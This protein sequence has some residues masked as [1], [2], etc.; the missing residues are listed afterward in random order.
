MSV[1]SCIV[2]NVPLLCSDVHS[3]GGCACVGVGSIG[4]LSI[5]SAQFFKPKTALKI[6]SIKNCLQI[7][8]RTSTKNLGNPNKIG[9]L[10]QCQYPDGDS[11]L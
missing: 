4:K 6:Q 9:D 1:G 8:R 5:L 2:T 11:V 10:H 3:G 7:N